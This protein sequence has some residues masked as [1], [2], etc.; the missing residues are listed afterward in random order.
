MSV[1]IADEDRRPAGTCGA[2]ATMNPRFRA[3]SLTFEIIPKAK[4][5]FFNLS[6]SVVGVYSVKIVNE[7]GVDKLSYYAKL[8]D[9]TAFKTDDDIM[10]V[11]VK[12][13][14]PSEYYNGGYYLDTLNKEAVEY[15][16]AKTHE[17][18]KQDIGD[19]F[20]RE[21]VGIYSTEPIRGPM[22]SPLFSGKDWKT[23]CPYSYET[24]REFT[25]RWQYDLISRLPELF[26]LKTGENYSIVTA[27]Y[28]EVINNQFLNSYVIPYYEWCKNN[29]LTL[30]ANFAGEETLASQTMLT[31]SV[32]NCYRY[33][34]I[35]YPN[36]YRCFP[37]RLHRNAS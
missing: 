21:L 9:A 19:I 29:N 14:E 3:K 2:I 25:A 1:Y 10:V 16:L 13:S 24:E 7:N 15:Y 37:H 23:S 8:D 36:F 31:G 32:M 12:E 26:F 6:S 17:K 27:H 20:G 5:S 30:L 33:C 28:C 34:D 4:F 18:Y 22:F 11:S 35:H